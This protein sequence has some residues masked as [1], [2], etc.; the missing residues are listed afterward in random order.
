LCI[1]VKEISMS[2]KGDLLEGKVALVTGSSRGIGRVI[3]Q[4]LA[5]LGASVAVHGSSLTSSRAFD[6]ADSL[7]AVARAVAKETGADVLP[8]HGDVRDETA[9]KGIVAAVRARFGHI[10]ILVNNAGGDIGAKG[11][12]GANFGRPDPNDCVFISVEDLKAVID[13]NLLSCVLMCREVAPEMMERRSGRIVNLT[14]GAASL[15]REN[16]G[17]YGTAKAGVSHYTR[18]LSVQMRPYN[19]TVN[20]IAPGIIVT[21]RIVATGQVDKA[22]LHE[23]PSLEGYGAPMDIAKAVE[24]FVS[25]LGDYVT[26]QILRVDGGRQTWPC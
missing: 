14:S 12:L 9:V 10:D 26:A 24:F 5:G 1:A 21:P 3:A 4:H 11:T 13:R 22:H 17:I 2:D 20:A 8:V 6:E 18:C 16:G 19:V 15:G 25:P 7:E 23:D